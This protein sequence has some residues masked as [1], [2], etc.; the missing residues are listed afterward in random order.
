MS[1]AAVDLS[2]E[3]GTTW[4]QDIV[5]K[6]SNDDPVDVSGYTGLMQVRETQESD[7]VVVAPTI[8]FGTT[9]GAITLSLTDTQTAGLDAN[10][11]RAWVY[12]L[13]VTSP[14]GTVTKLMA[15]Q[16]NVV[17]AVSRS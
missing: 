12:D 14:S 6:D 3:Q 16:F 13:F 8:V 17:A 9:D 10:G 11:D 5:W 7:V 4:E 1:A 2:V 15:G